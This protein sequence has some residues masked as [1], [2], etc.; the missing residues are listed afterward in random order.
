MTVGNPA[1]RDLMQKNLKKKELESLLE[2]NEQEI[3]VGEQSREKN[4][5]KSISTQ[6]LDIS[7]IFRFRLEKYNFLREKKFVGETLLFLHFIPLDPD[8]RIQ[9]NAG[10]TGS[11]FISLL[12]FNE[13]DI[14]FGELYLSLLS[15]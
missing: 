13:Q 14:L 10:P 11:G 4:I 2:F 3:P 5:F 6:P 7:Y 15:W 9:M 12:K 8:P 1:T